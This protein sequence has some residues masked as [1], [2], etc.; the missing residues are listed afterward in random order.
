VRAVEIV[1][2]RR[3]VASALAPV[4]GAP[5]KPALKTRPAL[6]GAGA[7]DFVAVV[8]WAEGPGAVRVPAKSIK[9]AKPGVLEA[10]RPGARS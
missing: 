10:P 5:S 3:R 7:Y 1:E 9:A 6:Q 2:M 4:P 8:R